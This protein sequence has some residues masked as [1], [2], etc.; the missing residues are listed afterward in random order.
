MFSG[1]SDISFDLT[2]TG[3]TPVVVDLPDAIAADSWLKSRAYDRN[4]DSWSALNAAYFNV[5]PE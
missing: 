1:S 5:D 3:R 2:L 4:S